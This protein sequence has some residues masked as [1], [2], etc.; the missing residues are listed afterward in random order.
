LPGLNGGGALDQTTM[1]IKDKTSNG[2]LLN[3]TRKKLNKTIQ[4]RHQTMYFAAT[5]NENLVF[6]VFCQCEHHSIDMNR[7]LY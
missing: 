6:E 7:T 3:K 4:Q 5:S 1:K 2:E